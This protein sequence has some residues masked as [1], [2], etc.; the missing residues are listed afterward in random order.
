MWHT[1]IGWRG[2]NYF[3]RQL[4]WRGTPQT[5]LCLEGHQRH[6]HTH[7]LGLLSVDRTRSGWHSLACRTRQLWHDARECAVLRFQ[8]LVFGFQLLQLLQEI[9][10]FGSSY[11]VFGWI[12]AKVVVSPKII[13][14]VTGIKAHK[15][16]FKNSPSTLEIQLNPWIS[17]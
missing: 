7:H 2:Q 6:T 11:S 4:W 16:K 9:E 5:K 15:T 1:Q 14:F 10:L 17:T 3:R 13:I 8:F 12:L